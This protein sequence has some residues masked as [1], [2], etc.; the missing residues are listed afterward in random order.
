M[1]PVRS[2]AVKGLPPLTRR[3]V[4]AIVAQL[5]SCYTTWLA[6]ESL[7]GAGL[8]GLTIAL[9]IEWLLFEG[10]RSVLVGAGGMVGLTCW[11]IDALLNAGG[12][13]SIVLKLDNTESYKMLA[14]ALSLGEDMRLIPA[15]LIALALGAWLSIAPHDLWRDE[16]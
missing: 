2:K 8:A 15:L 14:S 10:K 6:V 5:A 4:A 11:A 3:K 7:G 12:L 1:A 16:K 13:W 9:V